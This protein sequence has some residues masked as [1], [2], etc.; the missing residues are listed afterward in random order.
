MVLIGGRCFG[1]G[2]DERWCNQK[3]VFTVDS[4]PLELVYNSLYEPQH[5]KYYFVNG[6]QVHMNI[7]VYIL[8]FEYE[9][10]GHWRIRS[11]QFG[12]SSH[13]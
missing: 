4:V 12:Y 2:R 3:R 8:A 6:A 7:F 10:K 9:K 11:Y 1:A 13:E 5:L